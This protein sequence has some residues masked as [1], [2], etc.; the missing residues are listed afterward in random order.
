MKKIVNL[1]VFSLIFGI[2][3]IGCATVENHD[4]PSPFEGEWKMIS[5]IDGKDV[6]FTWTFT[7]NQF[8]LTRTDG[9]NYTGTFKYSKKKITEYYTGVDT[10]TEKYEI[11]DS[12]LRLSNATEYTTVYTTVYLRTPY[13]ELTQ[14]L[15]NDINELDNFPTNENELANIQG[16]W[17]HPNPLA[18][19]A[20]YIFIGN[21]FTR[22][23]KTQTPVSGTLKIND[24]TLILIVDNK[25]WGAYKI[26][27]RPK[28]IL[29]LNELYGHPDSWWGWFRKQ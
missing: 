17:K 5:N 8:K 19:G 18:K 1:A 23:S 2:I 7:D 20:T 24:N 15:L 4:G 11:S 9:K 26:E 21:E 3:L 10:F 13:F 22:T 25:P 27:F 28:N 29:Y 6:I 14:K 16:S 12:T